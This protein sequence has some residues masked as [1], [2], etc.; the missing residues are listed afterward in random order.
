MGQPNIA[1]D[2]KQKA[3]TAVS[4][5]ARGVAC[6]IV[7]D[8]TVEGLHI[9]TRKQQ[10]KEEYATE[11]KELLEICFDRYGTN[12]V[13]VYSI[14]DADTLANALKV[15]KK[16][17]FNYMCCYYDILEDD[18]KKLKDF[19]TERFEANKGVIIV[20]NKTVDSE[21][22]V[23]VKQTG[24]E[25]KEYTT[26]PTHFVVETTMRFASLPFNQSMTNKPLPFV[27]KCDELE[28]EDGEAN[29]GNLII[30]Y[31]GERYKY[32]RAV[33]GLQTVADGKTADMK[34]VQ[35]VE[36][37]CLVKG[38]IAS[39][40]ESFI[41]NYDNTDTNR[42]I[43]IAEANEYLRQLANEGVLNSKYNNHLEIDVEAMREYMEST[44]DLQ[45]NAKES[46]DTSAMSDEEVSIDAEGWTDTTVFVKGFIKFTKAIE[47]L[48]LNMYM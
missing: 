19:A 8:T 15:L 18:I 46:H 33:T 28:D 5:S 3:N 42:L 7:K 36:G 41:G 24:L 21:F 23:N 43:F 47:D 26:S 10:I 27:K 17:P 45:G 31:D 22:F 44:T 32:G 6:I 9:Y 35:I 1:I 29:R 14:K 48:K 38:D 25:D 11:T 12:K 40:F 13:L 30:R 20:T 2:F 4:R 34:N 16:K 37:M 39:E